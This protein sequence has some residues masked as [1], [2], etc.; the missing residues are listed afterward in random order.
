MPEL[1]EGQYYYGR[2]RASYG[3]W[4]VGKRGTDGARIDEFIA[5]FPTK[6]QAEKFVYKCNGWTKKQE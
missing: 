5:D 6:I 1:R 3:V 2:H 4:K